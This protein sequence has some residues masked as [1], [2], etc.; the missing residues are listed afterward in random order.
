MIGFMPAFQNPNRENAA[1][2]RAGVTTFLCPSDGTQ[3]DGTWP[4]QNNYLASQ[5]VQFMCDL[6]ESQ[7]STLA[8]GERP[9]GPLYYL[10]K[11][12]MTD[13]Q[14]GTSNTAVFSEKLRGRGN[15][16]PK[17]DLRWGDKSE[18][19]MMTSWIEYIDASKSGSSE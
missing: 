6:T 10:S 14:D 12:K 13:L 8:P 11:I 1:A 3:V 19:E 9:D 18:E 5:G 16:D 2:S 7:A 17:A 15:P 4:G